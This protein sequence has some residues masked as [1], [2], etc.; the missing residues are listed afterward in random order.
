MAATKFGPGTVTFT[1][2]TPPGTAASFEQ[3][4]KG[5]GITHEYED[6]GES[7]VYLDGSSTP[8]SATRADTLSLDCDFNL[9]AAGFYK[10]LFDNDLQQ[11]TAEFTPETAVGAKWAGTVQL[12]LPGEVTGEEFGAL[13]TGTVELAFVGPA[14]FTAGS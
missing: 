12:R 8:V 7:V 6:I 9:G 11:A 4:A 14:V 5:G 3:E 10:F 2:V 13:L 1:V